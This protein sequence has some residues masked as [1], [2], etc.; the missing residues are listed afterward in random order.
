M[1]TLIAT[2]DGALLASAIRRVAR[3][4]SGGLAT[5]GLISDSDGEFYSGLIVLVLTEGWSIYR[6]WRAKREA[7]APLHAEETPPK[8]AGEAASDPKP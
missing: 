7:R 6:D 1:N 8:P 2:I 5:K 4:V 3:Y